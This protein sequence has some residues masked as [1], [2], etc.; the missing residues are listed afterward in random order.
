MAII[1]PAG[2]IPDKNKNPLLIR[3]GIKIPLLRIYL[4]LGNQGLL[5]AIR[6]FF[7]GAEGL[8]FFS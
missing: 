4:G 7:T 3:Q 2:P 6:L 1:I 8:G 5:R